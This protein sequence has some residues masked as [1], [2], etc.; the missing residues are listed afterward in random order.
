MN[1]SP[2]E[3]RP[4]EILM[5]EDNPGDIRLTREALREARIRNRVSV[6]QDGVAGLEFLKKQGAH[7]NAV[8]PDLVLLD[9]NLP[10]KNGKAVLAEI[11]SDPALRHIPT[12]VLTSS[13]A[14]EDIARS[15]DLQANCYIVKPVDMVQLIAVM[16]SV[17]RFWFE[18]VTLPGQAETAS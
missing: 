13:A 16:Q 5:I 15:Y 17:G 1:V 11:K 6:A 3:R 10:K 4:I 14:E 12:V 7:E 9:L 8:T 2:S 18:I